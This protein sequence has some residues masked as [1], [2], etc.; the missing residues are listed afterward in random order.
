MRDKAMTV[1]DLVQILQRCDQSLHIA[2]HA[3]NTT[4][5]GSDAT[6]RVGLLHHYTG[7]HVVIGTITKR[8]INGKNWHVA[9]ML[10]GGPPVPRDWGFGDTRSRTI[11]I[12]DRSVHECERC[13]TLDF[14]GSETVVTGR[15][16]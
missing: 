11:F 15:R 5:A 14:D 13:D 10:D 1:G 4:A 3:L 12:G 9:E 2:T 7:D 16:V 8:D 6:M